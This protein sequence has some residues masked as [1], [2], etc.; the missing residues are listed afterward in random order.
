MITRRVRELQRRR[1]VGDQGFAM[2]ELMVAMVVFALLAAGV[3]ASLNMANA[4]GRGNRLRVVA[5]NLA[6]SQIETVRNYDVS[7]L[8]DGISCPMAGGTPP[9]GKS[10]VGA[11]AFYVQQSV[12]AVPIDAASSACDSPSGSEARLQA[13]HGSGHLGRD[14]HD[15]AGPFGHPHDPGCERAGPQQGQHRRE[16]SG[17]QRPPAGRG[18]GQHQPRRY[19]PTDRLRRLRHLHQPQPRHDLHDDAQHDRL[20]GPERG[21]DPGPER[22]RPQHRHGEP[23]VQ[24]R[25]STTTSRRGCRWPSTRRTR[26]I[27][28]PRRC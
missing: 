20:R 10:M 3:L 8:V 23:G 28:C 26:P 21:G 25:I 1:A 13:D 11:D 9:C 14:G 18:P 24:G 6:A 16:G 15:S 17:P 27:R 4:T 5:A 12:E 19:L 7:L 2:V 22:R